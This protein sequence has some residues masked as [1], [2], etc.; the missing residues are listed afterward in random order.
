MLFAVA[1]DLLG[2]AVSMDILLI[3][4]FLLM[5]SFIM[6]SKLKSVQSRYVD[7][8]KNP[9]NMKNKTFLE[10]LQRHKMSSREDTLL[11]NQKDF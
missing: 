8:S 10:L 3:C 6:L 7:T 9:Q 11:L 5:K 2:R 1:R 4:V